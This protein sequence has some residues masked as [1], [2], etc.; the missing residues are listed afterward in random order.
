MCETYLEYA[1]S[2]FVSYVVMRLLL[3]GATM[4][5]AATNQRRP[6]LK[7]DIWK[8]QA[9]LPSMEA[10]ALISAL[11]ISAILAPLLVISA[12]QK[13]CQGLYTYNRMIMLFNSGNSVSYGVKQRLVIDNTDNRCVAVS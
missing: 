13:R 3:A 9:K 1:E 10:L 5:A 4:L 7:H 2:N 8:F 6:L 11:R 12:L